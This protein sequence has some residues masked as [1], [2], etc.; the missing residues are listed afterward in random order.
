[1]NDVASQRECV[2]VTGT[3]EAALPSNAWAASNLMERATAQCSQA[4][5]TISIK[6]KKLANIVQSKSSMKSLEDIVASDKA[7]EERL[8]NEL[9]VAVRDCIRLG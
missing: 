7:G 1:M 2:P 8:K 5:D 6:S 4:R 3:R 9:A